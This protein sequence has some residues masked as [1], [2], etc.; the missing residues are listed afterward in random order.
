MRA[1]PAVL[2]KNVVASKPSVAQRIPTFVRQL[3]LSVFGFFVATSISILFVRF[4]IGM[5]PQSE[6]VAFTTASASLLAMVSSFLIIRRFASFPLLRTYNYAALTLISIFIAFAVGLKGFGIVY[7]S[8]Q[9][10]LA[11][12]IIMGL[13]EV[14]LYVSRHSRPLHIAVVPGGSAV[15]KLPKDPSRPINYNLLQ[16]VPSG[17]FRFSAVIADLTSPLEPEW[18]T[19][20]ASAA[21]RNIPVYHIK[22]FRESITGRVTLDH[23]WENSLVAIVPA[24]IYPQFKRMLDLL[25]ALLLLPI[26]GLVIGVSAI[27]IKLDTGGPIFFRHQRIGLGGRPFAVFK[28]RTMIDDHNGEHYTVPGDERVTWVGR[29]CANIVLMSCRRSSTFCAGR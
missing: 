16:R 12:L 11:M 9:F 22:Q 4:G 21:L 14:F 10:F 2:I 25:G 17:D 15:S 5:S 27:L 18:E 23:L 6:H 28:L 13:V 29:F 7:S 1:D 24:L 19:F 20:L 26:I 8:P 3:L